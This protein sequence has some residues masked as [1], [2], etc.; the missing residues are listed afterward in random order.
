MSHRQERD[1]K[2]NLQRKKRVKREKRLQNPTGLLL[3]KTSGESNAGVRVARGIKTKCGKGKKK[4]GRVA[5]AHANTLPKRTKRG[6]QRR[7]KSKNNRAGVVDSK[8]RRVGETPI[9]H[10]LKVRATRGRVEL[11]TGYSPEQ[12]KVKGKSRKS[13]VLRHTKKLLQTIRTQ[14]FEIEKVAWKSAY[15]GN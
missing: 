14:L 6:N 15:T 5:P 11:N 9:K 8:E 3:K 12:A 1:E 10:V 4:A 7:K 2:G 13:K